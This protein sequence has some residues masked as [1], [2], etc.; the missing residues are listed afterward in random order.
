MSGHLEIFLNDEL[1]YLLPQR[2]IF[3][4]NKLQLILSD[5]H[6]GKG[7]HFRTH[8]LPLPNT[9]HLKDIDT[10]HYLIDK[11]QPKTVF[12]L[13]DLFHS[14][15]NR[16]WLWFKSLLLHYQAVEFVLIE[17]NHDILE[18]TH[19][20]SHNLV[21]TALYE[22]DAFVFTHH[23]L[24]YTPKLNICGHVH[25]G[26]RIEGLARQSEKLPCFFLGRDH[27]ILPAF[28]YLTG[29][30]ILDPTESVACF[31][32]AGNRVVRLPK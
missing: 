8:G 28:G 7:T 21:K 18:D 5:V 32:I 2:A 31:L 16:E 30:R 26:T 25:P 3:R 13:G 9:T 15:Y 19:Y 11:W 24:N 1:I 12:I 27:F 4:P 23:P 6:L 20:S 22:D 10:L 17:G 29:L 14:D